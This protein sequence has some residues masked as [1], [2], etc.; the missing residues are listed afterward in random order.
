M[1]KIKDPKV[2][3]LEEPEVEFRYNQKLH[4]PHHGLSLFG[5]FDADSPSAPKSLSVGVI[6]TPDGIA[7]Y[8]R[9]A[10]SIQ[11]PVYPR[12]NLNPKIWPLYPGFEAIFGCRWPEESA[13]EKTLDSKTLEHEV[14]NR[15]ANQRVYNIVDQYMMGIKEAIERD[16]SFDIL[17]CIV[18]DLVWKYCRPKSKV[19]GGYGET[20]SWKERLV[21]VRQTH[22]FG[23]YRPEQYE[24]SL[25][26]RRQLKARA[27]ENVTPPPDVAWNLT[28]TAYYKAGGKPWRLVSAR[29]G[30]CYV[31]IVFRRTELGSTSPSACC[32]AQMFLDTGDGVVFRGEF[33]PW[34]SSKD[35]QYHLSRNAAKS[36]LEGVLASYDQLHG[37]PLKEVFLH[38]R[39][40]ISEE[41]FAGYKDACSDEIEVVGIRVRNVRNGLKLY[42]EGRF[43]VIRGTMVEINDRSSYLLAAGFVPR[44]GT[45]LGWEVPNPLQIDIQHG[46]ADIRQVCKDILG[47]T[48]LNYNACKFGHSEPVTISF[49]DDV[50]EILVANRTIKNPKSQFKYYI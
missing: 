42:R 31:G 9:W 6:G 34:Y 16:E 41:E 13:W 48:K 10:S 30:V 2:H 47:L 40:E 8:R 15:D 36:L 45:Y 20:V 43:P 7:G 5:P 11:R 46:D 18:P 17:L 1:N 22:L 38:C 29:E 24:Y 50:G 26:F 32:A 3:I 21:R 19:V 44:L 4:D 23:I 39:S 49:S 35:R 37:Q 14:L 25:D 33:G 12:D 27:M 28:S